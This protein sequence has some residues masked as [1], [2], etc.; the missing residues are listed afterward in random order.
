MWRNPLVRTYKTIK[1]K[2]TKSIS[3]LIQYKLRYKFAGKLL[4]GLGLLVAVKP[5]GRPG[6]AS[7]ASSVPVNLQTIKRIFILRVRGY[8]CL[9][10]LTHM[11]MLFLP[12]EVVLQN[13]FGD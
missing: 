8:S 13:R 6:N 9:P 10:E 3:P 11:N 7:P 4:I 2:R 5:C 12:G 1:K